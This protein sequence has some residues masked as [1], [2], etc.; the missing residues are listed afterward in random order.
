MSIKNQTLLVALRITKPQLTAKDDTGTGAAET[1]T[2]ASNA[3]QYRKDLYPKALIAPILEV[4][5]SA[6]AFVRSSTLPWTA[7]ARMLPTKKFMEFNAKMNQFE[8][9]YNQ[10]VTVF[11]NN[12]SNVLAAAQQQQGSMFDPSLY[13]D[14][15]SLRSQFSFKPEFYPVSDAGDFRLDLDK[16]QTAIIEQ[17]A[18]QQAQTS[19]NEAAQD[20]LQ[21]LTTTLT[22]FA[23]TMA[24]PDR[25]SINA[26]TGGVDIKPP[27]FR[28]S[29]VENIKE[30][31]D[32]AEGFAHILPP[33]A[34]DKART[35]VATL[36]TH[37]PEAL[38]QDKELRKQMAAKARE[39]LQEDGIT[40]PPTAWKHPAAVS[41]L[42][43][44]MVAKLDELDVVVPV[45]AET[46]T[47][48]A[49]PAPVPVPDFFT[50]D[51][52]PALEAAAAETQPCAPS[53]SVNVTTPPVQRNLLDVLAD[54]ED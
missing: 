8:I 51:L 31:A 2:G 6:R 11:L 38:R 34:L 13:P 18:V 29:V 24:K 41:A 42:P 15:S 22:A 45:S 52:D 25:T 49:A 48:P 39:I 32:F 1:A 19:L 4:E 20:V 35:A 37:T 3:G 53:T 50:D 9:A 21:R 47:A 44:G 12:Y 40:L 16:E 46:T 36:T 33:E 26:K 5:S 30:L 28:D 7:G 54:L 14:L 17:A 27:I 43:A 10:S 23:T